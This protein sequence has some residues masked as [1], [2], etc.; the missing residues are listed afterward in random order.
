MNV[1]KILQTLEA[2]DRASEAAVSIGERVL[3]RIGRR[4]A[5]WHRWR[6]F[7]LR[8]RASRIEAGR[9]R[10]FLSAR[11]RA[12]I[13]AALR[14]EAGEHLLTAYYAEHRVPP[15]EKSPAFTELE[16]LADGHEPLAGSRT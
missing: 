9:R 2:A 4:S 14:A 7:R 6:A 12:R 3:G 1:D 16:A 8:L 13:V 10:P 15:P 5:R 11:D